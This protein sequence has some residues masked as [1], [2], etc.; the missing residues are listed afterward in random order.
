MTVKHT[1]NGALNTNLEASTIGEETNA[2][3]N[4]TKFTVDYEVIN[5]TIKEL[6]A[7]VALFGRSDT[8]SAITQKQAYVDKFILSGAGSR[9]SV[10]FEYDNTTNEPTLKVNDNDPYPIW[11]NNQPLLTTDLSN[12]KAGEIVTFIFDGEHWVINRPSGDSYLQVLDNG[13]LVHD[14]NGTSGFYSQILA[15]K[16]RIAYNNLMSV[17]VTN[18]T[19]WIGDNNNH[20]VNIDPN[21]ISITNDTASLIL[22]G[23][24]G[25]AQLNEEGLDTAQVVA[26]NISLVTL[27]KSARTVW[28]M[29]NNSH[30]SWKK[31]GA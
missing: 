10:K 7:D 19:I 27:D 1:F 30:T 8:A 12:W 11:V 31:A 15:D 17:N 2:S 6:I 21:G 25:R 22:Q 3:S 28:Q 4:Q 18:D 5:K 9:V 13:I 26:R 16:I 14:G 29:R 23:L 20:G 24:T